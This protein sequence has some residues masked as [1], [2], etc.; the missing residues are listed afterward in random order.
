MRL[1]YTLLYLHLRF[2]E[3]LLFDVGRRCLFLKADTVH[4]SGK[5]NVFRVQSACVPQSACS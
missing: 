1:R 4:T 3:G 5:V 2:S